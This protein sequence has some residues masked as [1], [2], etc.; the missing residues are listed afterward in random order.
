MNMINLTLEM[1]KQ[2]CKV[3]RNVPRIK[4]V[5]SAK[6]KIAI[7]LSDSQTN[8]VHLTTVVVTF[9]IVQKNLGTHACKGTAKGR[10]EAT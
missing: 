7:S 5:A 2:G 4:Q 1:M 8:T 10:N 3:P 6:G 9:K